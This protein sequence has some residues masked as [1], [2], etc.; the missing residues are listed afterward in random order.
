MPVYE[1]HCASC[2]TNYDVVQSIKAEPLKTC[3][4]CGQDAIE[5]VLHVPMVLDLTP[6]TLG[7]Q[8]DKNEGPGRTYWLDKKRR[9]ME[10]AS[11]KPERPWWRDTDHVNTKLAELTPKQQMNYVMTGNSAEP[12]TPE[13]S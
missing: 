9:E 10:Q 3:M 7:G 12:L 5:R 11:P 1:Y 6:K 13:I 8:A 4:G 2:D